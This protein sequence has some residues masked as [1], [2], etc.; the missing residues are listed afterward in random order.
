MTK[1]KLLSD[2]AAITAYV[3]AAQEPA[4]SRLRTLAVAIRE[5]L[6][7]AVERIAYGLPTWH[8]GENL[9]HLGAF[10]HHV[11]IYPGPAAIVTFADE[12][13]GYKTSKGTIQ[14]PHEAPLP[15]ELVRRITRWRVEQQTTKAVPRGSTGRANTVGVH[16]DVAAYIAAQSNE[17][18][19]VC[20]ALASHISAALPGAEGKVWHG[21]PV[22]FLEG[23]PVVGYSVHKEGT[24]LLFWSGQSFDEP[25]LAPVGKFKAA[26]AR[27]ATITDIDEKVLLRWLKKAES[28]LWDYTNLVKNKGQLTRLR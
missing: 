12:L 10:K 26:S 21:H 4:R 27:Y 24:R 23:N 25:G 2:P 22:W 15:I 19:A 8:Q 20:E 28:I 6:P 17:H 5:E 14:V 1:R 11:G 3:D 13:K 16:T 18:R 9:I 7:D